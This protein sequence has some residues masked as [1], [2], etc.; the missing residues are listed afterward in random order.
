MFFIFTCWGFNNHKWPFHDF[1][2]HWF[3]QS[4]RGIN[5]SLIEMAFNHRSGFR[6]RSKLTFPVSDV[7]DAKIPP[8]GEHEIIDSAAFRRAKWLANEKLYFI[9]SFFRRYVKR[10]ISGFHLLLDPRQRAARERE[11]NLLKLFL[12]K[13][14]QVTRRNF[15]VYIDRTW[16]L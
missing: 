10:A 6:C 15:S 12:K 2:L 8:R 4:E 1:A 5:S 11:R 14:H 7:S 16:F 9:A 3:T 13:V